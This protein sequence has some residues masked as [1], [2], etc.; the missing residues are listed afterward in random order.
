MNTRYVI[1][2]ADRSPEWP[3]SIVRGTLFVAVVFSMPLTACA[4]ESTKVVSPNGRNLLVLQSTGDDGDHV[5]FAVKRDGRQIVR[6]SALGPVLAAGQLLGD[7]AR[8][9]G[10]RHGRVNER[11]Q[12]PWGKTRPLPTAAR[13]LSSRWQRV[14]IIKWEV[15]LRAY[16]DGVA[17]RYRLPRQRGLSKFEIRDEVTQFDVAG[18]PAALFNTLDSFTTSHE[19]LYE[20]KPLSAIPA[21]QIA[22]HATV[23][24]LAGRKSG[25]D[26]R[27]PRA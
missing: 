23:A 24:I 12:L 7:G 21:R 17:F 27:G 5:R 25:R 18:K 8:I 20:R 26:H 19:S 13:M 15:E 22:G 11:F 4:D 3:T 16:D 14:R 1:P 2:I 10:V 9:V 6:P